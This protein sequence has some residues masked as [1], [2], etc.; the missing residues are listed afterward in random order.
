[1][2][3]PDDLHNIQTHE[4][5]HT[6]TKSRETIISIKCKDLNIKTYSRD[7]AAKED[8]FITNDRKGSESGTVDHQRGVWT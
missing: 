8:E 2:M 7:L 3:H 1:M 5:I 4:R 6:A